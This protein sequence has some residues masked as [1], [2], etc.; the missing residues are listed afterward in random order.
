[1]AAIGCP[2]VGDSEYGKDTPHVGQ[3]IFLWATRLELA[4]PITHK[5]RT[6]SQPPPSKFGKLWANEE[7]VW[8]MAMVRGAAT[9][10]HM[11][12]LRE[13]YLH[14]QAE[15]HG[16]AAMPPNLLE[17]RA[18][19]SPGQQGEEPDNLVT[20]AALNQLEALEP[21]TPREK[22]KEPD[23]SVTLAPNVL[24]ARASEGAPGQL[25]DA[26]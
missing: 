22:A 21:D 9:K 8:D 4:D 19:D 2:I 26:S 25:A 5:P 13:Q 14:R 23:E 15:E 24:E 12:L 16:G 7:K 6:F 17:A 20:L 18:P 11:L 1:M 3:A 10:T